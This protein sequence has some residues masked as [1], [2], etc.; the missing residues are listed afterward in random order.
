MAET[1]EFIFIDESGDPGAAGTPVYILAALHVDEEELHCIREH[2]TAFRYHGGVRKE[3]QD[4]R[5]HEK[6]ASAGDG[7]H[8]LLAA[9]AERCN[10]GA[11]P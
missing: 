7:T 5:G 11:A 10:G 2:L 8:R 1:K 3:F 4:S 9:I 6:P